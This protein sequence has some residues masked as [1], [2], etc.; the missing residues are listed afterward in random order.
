MKA[1]CKH[2]VL[3]AWCALFLLTVLSPQDSA[4]AATLYWDSDSSIAGDNA[5]GTGLGGAGAW[6]LS[7]ANWWNGASLGLWPNTSADTAIFSAP[8]TLLPTLSTVTLSS[9][10]TAGQLSFLR[11]GFTLT[12]G[13]LTL[14][15]TTPTLSAALGESVTI[16]SQILGSA[17]LTMLGGGNDPARQQ[18]QHLHRHDHPQ[19]RFAYHHQ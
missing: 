14:A 2:L 9:G 5:D 1:H 8:L 17:G 15:G 11:S 16:N 19:Q 12:G 18:C 3:P 7:T 4:Q 10:I 6:D 13:D